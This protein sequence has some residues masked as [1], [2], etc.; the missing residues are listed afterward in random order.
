MK[1]RNTVLIGAL[2]LIGGLVQGQEESGVVELAE[3]PVE[4]EKS[5]LFTS[6]D[7][8]S[9]GSNHAANFG[10]HYDWHFGKKKRIVVG[11]GLRFQSFFGKD[12]VF[13]SAPP[14]F[15]VDPVNQDTLLAPAPSIFS[16]NAILNLGYRVTPKIFLGFN[17]D[18]FGFSFGP[19][20]SPTYVSNGVEQV[21]KVNPSPINALLVGANDLGSLKAQ[22]YGRYK[23]SDKL[24]V[25]A[26]FQNMFNE[27]TTETVIQTVPGD[28]DRFRS[29]SAQ[30]F[31]GISYFF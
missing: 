14:E 8:G 10:L 30:G 4:Y 9:N 13:V 31:A 22:F 15:Y 3:V 11:S 2:L 27:L 29:A 6:L 7:F 12:V 28:N 24:A 18:V 1:T 26:G 5:A 21:V 17:I 19:N 16:V 20:G 23:F 25:Q